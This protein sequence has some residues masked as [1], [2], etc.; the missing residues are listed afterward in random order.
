MLLTVRA[1]G[2]DAAHLRAYQ[3]RADYQANPRG[4][5]DPADV[6]Y[7]LSKRGRYELRT[8]DIT[9]AD[10]D[11]R[12]AYTGYD[13]NSWVPLRLSDLEFVPKRLD[14][15]FAN[16]VTLARYSVD[17]SLSPGPATTQVVLYWTV[18]D[19]PPATFT[20]QLLIVEPNGR[21]LGERTAVPTQGKVPVQEWKPGSVVREI[22]ALPHA[23]SVANAISANIVL[24]LLDPA[25]NQPWQLVNAPDGPPY[26]LARLKIAR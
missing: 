8:G 17:D 11:F 10:A 4:A 9:A 26:P 2:V 21:T 25:T 12:R 23:A 6:S 24:T 18:R 14:W 22:Y 16:G 19:Q 3:S 1:G 5:G 15:Q 13:K 20:V 7:T